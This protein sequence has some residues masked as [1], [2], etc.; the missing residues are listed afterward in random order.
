VET[1]TYR[2]LLLLSVVA[3]L[4]VAA[5]VWRR[6]SAPA[7]GSLAVLLLAM[8]EWALAVLLSDLARDTD[9]KLLFNT[10]SYAGIVAVPVAWLAIA[11]QYAGYHRSLTRARL[12]LLSLVPAVSLVVASTNDAHGLFWSAVEIREDGAGVWFDL[13]VGPWFVVH[14][15][16]SYLLIAAA[17]GLM[18]RTIFGASAVYGKQTT[19]YLAASALPWAVNA[20]YHFGIELF[21]GRDATPAAYG[22]SALLMAV[23]HARF[24]L[25]DVVP[26]ARSA[27]IEGLSDAVIVVDAAHRIAELNPTAGELLGVDVAD[28]V[29]ESAAEVLAEHPI[30]L[31]QCEDRSESRQEVTLIAADGERQ[32]VLR[33]ACLSD[34]GSSSGAHLLVLR[35]ITERKRADRELASYRDHLEDL[36]EQRTNELMES[37]DKLR[38]SERLASLGT[39]AAGIAHEI[40]NPLAVIRLAAEYARATEGDSSGD[41]VLRKALSDITIQADR[42]NRIVRNVMRFSRG[43]PTE[44]WSVDANEVAERACDMTAVH[45][46]DHSASVTLEPSPEPAPVLMSPIE[47]EQVLVNLI[48][49]AIESQSEG[50][51]VVVRV[52]PRLNSLSIA[53]SDNGCGIE[54]DVLKHIFDPFYTT[55]MHK[56]GSGLGLSV[57]HGIVVDHRGKM[58]VESLRGEGTT[59]TVELPLYSRG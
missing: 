18:I 25:L 22:F 49:N 4:A 46:S 29:G 33:S 7:S 3:S 31:R 53:V 14:T 17:A 52:E 37:R 38:Q 16:Y 28:A 48:R 44:K 56:G 58:V 42:C 40:N 34:R 43:M 13:A 1:V 9:T 32:Y 23:G 2:L 47:M 45:A 57:A 36:V 12:L 39:L 30:L 8:A 27:I 24:Q 51:Q 15:V 26:V 19:F 59:I 6:R 55:R 5:Q 54:Q 35:D 50:A 11:L 10:A 41:P 21:P 20:F